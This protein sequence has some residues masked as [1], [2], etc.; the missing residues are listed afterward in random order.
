MTA[1]LLRMCHLSNLPDRRF[2]EDGQRM[3]K[4]CRK[5]SQPPSQGTRLRILDLCK[6]TFSRFSPTLARTLAPLVPP[7]LQ[8]AFAFF[9]PPLLDSTLMDMMTFTH[10]Q[11]LPKTMPALDLQS[12]SVPRDFSLNV[13]S[14]NFRFQNDSESEGPVTPVDHN[15]T[16]QWNT[17]YQSL[18]NVFASTPEALVPTE[19]LLD[20]CHRRSYDPTL[21][22]DAGLVMPY[23]LP[24]PPVVTTAS[25]P[26]DVGSCAT[27]AATMQAAV[28]PSLHAPIA[29]SP[30]SALL[31]WTP[32][33][34]P[35]TEGYP[36]TFD[37]VSH[38]YALP[39]YDQA[40]AAIHQTA[41]LSQPS[42]A[43]YV[44]QHPQQFQQEPAAPYVAPYT[45]TDGYWHFIPNNPSSTYPTP[46]YTSTMSHYAMPVMTPWS[47]EPSATSAVTA[48]VHAAPAVS[49]TTPYHGAHASSTQELGGSYS[50][51]YSSSPSVYS[52]FDT[53]SAIPSSSTSISSI[54]STSVAQPQAQA[55]SVSNQ[56][57]PSPSQ[58]E[59]TRK[60]KRSTLDR[61]EECEGDSDDGFGPT[62]D[63]W[64]SEKR[65]RYYAATD[66]RRRSLA[67]HVGF[68]PTDP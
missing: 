28:V 32:P 16:Q 40:Q 30:H 53:Q 29:R 49:Q 6:R 8:F 59:V 67:E 4:E 35:H 12:V 58:Q 14:T 48:A 43:H 47:A 36:K 37:P 19:Q 20:A 68:L 46:T 39:V 13:V 33:D 27:M 9:R 25:T 57:Y 26:T 31:A 56:W 62:M 55:Q 65:A 24:P 1:N 2:L 52:T 34:A 66:V 7:P 64:P 21:S 50:Y 5:S 45:A 38:D 63:R 61:D 15:F 17:G 10:Y 22:N 51:S 42:F 44:P 3:S 41:V 18:P 23:T 60:R 11:T 54:S